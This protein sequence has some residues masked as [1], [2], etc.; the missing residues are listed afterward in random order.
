DLPRVVD[1]ATSTYDRLMLEVALTPALAAVWGVVTR[2][3]QFL[4][5]K[6]P[7]Q[8]AKDDANRDQLGSVLYA[9]AEMLRVLAVL[10]RPIMPSAAARLWDQLGIEASLE[11]QHVPAAAAWG[12]LQPGTR[13]RRGEALFPR[14]DA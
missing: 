7:W 2:A 10:V 3:N 8:L 5:E 4:V 13:I 6:E 1:E 11:D 12:L 9:A 14:L